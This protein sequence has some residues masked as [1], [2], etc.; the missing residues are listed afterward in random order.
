M[1]TLQLKD[2]CATTEDIRAYLNQ[3]FNEGDFTFATNGHVMLAVPRDAAFDG[4]SSLGARTVAVLEVDEP[5]QWHPLPP[6]EVEVPPGDPC[7]ACGGTGKATLA[8]CPECRGDG[9]I[10]FSNRH[11]TY[12]FDCK[13]CDGDGKVWAQS[14]ESG[15]C[16]RCNGTGEVDPPLHTIK[17]VSILNVA[18]QPK[19]AALIAGA[20]GLEVASSV[21]NKHMLMFR[22][23][24]DAGTVLAR[25]AIMGMSVAAEGDDWVLGRDA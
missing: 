2:F 12:W 8:V 23:V 11:H 5:H 22:Q 3:P 14:D 19:Y 6:V 18:V 24:D 21:K 17:P 13:T 9:E 7:A 1:R 15:S 25:G 10:E 4:N 16:A 20:P